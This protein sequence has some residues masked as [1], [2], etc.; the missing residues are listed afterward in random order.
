MFHLAKF[1]ISEFE[2]SPEAEEYAAYLAFIDGVCG[3]CSGLL[4][5]NTSFDLCDVPAELK[6]NIRGALTPGL[7]DTSAID[8]AK[9][10]ERLQIRTDFVGIVDCHGYVQFDSTEFCFGAPMTAGP[11]TP[12]SFLMDGIRHRPVQSASLLCNR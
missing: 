12:I 11:T 2:E 7:P 9:C 3:R 5:S 10:L 6:D 1:Y 4:G 8:L